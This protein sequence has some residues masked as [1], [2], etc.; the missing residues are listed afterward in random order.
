MEGVKVA[1]R[2]S[3]L[4]EGPID[5]AEYKLDVGE[6]VQATSFSKVY[7]CLNRNDGTPRIL[8]W[9]NGNKQEGK[10]IKKLV[11]PNI[12][13]CYGEF[14]YLNKHYLVLDYL[15]GGDLLEWIS[16]RYKKNTVPD[17]DECVFIARQILRAVCFVHSNGVVHGDLKP[18]NIVVSKMPHCRHGLMDSRRLPQIQ[19]IDFG[20]AKV[21]RDYIKNPRLY[22]VNFTMNYAAPEL[23]HFV[24]F[25]EKSGEYRVRNSILNAG[26]IFSKQSDMWST[27]LMIFVLLTAISPNIL[28]LTEYMSYWVAID[29][30]EDNLIEI[31]KKSPRSS[32]C[33]R[34]IKS[35]L[36][37]RRQNRISAQDALDHHW[38][39]DE[40]P[41]RRS[42]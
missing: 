37:F 42:I 41:I 32:S 25:D 31:S 24:K 6:L 21:L 39:N 38:L 15:P 9:V 18:E 12:V 30:M 13:K 23:M 20:N 22:N 1:R 8:K 26:P 29:D 16:T 19:L 7:K 40:K 33:F 4:P 11:H 3:A 34:L 36:A 35:M 28:I 2:G 17:E 27:G 5:H 10:I 14:E